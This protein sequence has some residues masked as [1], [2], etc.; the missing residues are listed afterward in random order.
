MPHVS[1]CIASLELVHLDVQLG[2]QQVIFEPS[3][4]GKIEGQ[5]RIAEAAVI[6]WPISMITCY[7]AAKSDLQNILT[8]GS[9]LT[10]NTD[11]IFWS[12]LGIWKDART[13]IHQLLDQHLYG[14]AGHVFA[15]ALVEATGGPI[16]DYSYHKANGGIL[17]YIIPDIL[18]PIVIPEPAVVAADVVAGLLYG[19]T[20]RDKLDNLGECFYGA[21]EFVYD[22]LHAYNDIA[23]QT[24]AGLMNGF[25]LLLSTVMYIPSDLVNC[26]HAKEDVK[27][28][29]EWA[30]I[31]AHPADLKSTFEY[32]LKH[33]FS[34]LAI[35]VNKARKHVIEQ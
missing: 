1:E 20:K 5:T 13:Q 34:S 23:S 2:L 32:N 30:S 7:H 10:T 15:H 11:E 18:P 14:A 27:A 21:D 6:D 4:G 19:I 24:F 22:L 16:P 35:E 33:H 25:T 26:Y 9:K 28:L 29:E 17:P 12:N 31:F 8:L 3:F